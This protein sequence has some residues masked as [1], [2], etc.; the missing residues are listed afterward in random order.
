VALLEEL[1]VKITSDTKGLDSN[2]DKSSKSV[3]SVVARVYSA[4]VIACLLRIISIFLKRLFL[5]SSTDSPGL[6]N[7]FSRAS[8][9]LN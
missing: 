1:I 6:I 5:A 9:G 7:P 4:S 3:G 8:S 2:L